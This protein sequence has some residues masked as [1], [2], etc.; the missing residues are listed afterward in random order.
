M[1]VGRH[2]LLVA[3]SGGGYEEQ[4][5]ISNG[6][7][8]NQQADSE[9]TTRDAQ[10]TADD[11]AILKRFKIIQLVGT[12]N[13]A[14]VYKSVTANGKELAVKSI[15]LSRTTEN[16]KQKFLP[17]ELNILRKISHVN[18]CKIHEIIQVADRIFIIMQFCSK[19][20]IADLLHRLGPL[21]EPVSR[22][23]FIQTCDAVIYLHSN[24][25][26]HRDIKV[27]NILLDHDY[28]PKLTDFSYSIN[29]NEGKH[30]ASRRATSGKTRHNL[31]KQSSPAPPSILNNTFCG[32]LP[33]LSPEMI[34]QHPYDAKK[35]DVWSLGIC[36]YVMLNDRLPFPF[37]DVKL[38]LKKQ[39]SRDF[40][41][42]TNIKFSEEIKEMLGF[43]LEPDFV[44]RPVL[45][46]IIKHP[47]ANGPREKPPP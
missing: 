32:T 20:T 36:L 21:S 34:R 31:N 43:M 39:L 2:M 41:L 1:P 5:T 46:D 27:E 6:Q 29:V 26:A 7:A 22:N 15:N 18:I 14:R 9:N 23:L 44:K 33:Y 28:C 38:M 30:N 35:T 3:T 40:K 37:N 17:R 24:D 8:D 13:Y 16:Y 47:W 10:E 45:S 4:M 19:G 12:G 25:F 42:K 11:A